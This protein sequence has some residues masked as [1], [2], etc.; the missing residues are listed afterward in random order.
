MPVPPSPVPFAVPKGS[1][2]IWWDEFSGDSLDTAWWQYDLG[3]G[4]W[5]W[6][7]DEKQYYTSSPANVGVANGQLYINAVRVG[8]VEAGMRLSCSVKVFRS[9]AVVVCRLRAPAR[10]PSTPHSHIPIPPLPH[11]SSPHTTPPSPASHHQGANNNFTSARINTK[12][13]ASFWPGM[14]LT[15][16]TTFSSVHV[17]ASIQMPQPGQGCVL[18]MRRQQQRGRKETERRGGGD[19]R[20]IFEAAQC[21]EGVLPAG[22]NPCLAQPACPPHIPRRCMCAMCAATGRLS[23]CSTSATR[24]EPGRHRA[25]WAGSGA[26]G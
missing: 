20:M 26:G 15:D 21:D 14:S 23:G 10:C 18:R 13:A 12:A 25:R 16:G 1:Q 3:N 8:G 6:G 9:W 2:A 19:G 11:L 7:N 22:Q 5:G 24:T 4:V 17:E